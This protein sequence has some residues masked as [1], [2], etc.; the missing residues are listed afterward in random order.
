[1]VKRRKI[2]RKLLVLLL[3]LGL[4]SAV[5]AATVN[6]TINGGTEYVGTP[7]EVVTIKVIADAKCFGISSLMAAEATTVNSA[8]RGTA[9]TDWDCPAL[10]TPGAGMTIAEPGYL[11]NSG[12]N[13]VLFDFFSEYSAD[14]VAAGT[15]LASF[16]YT[17][18][19]VLGYW[20]APLET[21]TLY[22]DI[23]GDPYYADKST[24]SLLVEG[25]PTD[26]TIG[27]VHIIP[28]PVTIV[29]LGLGGLLLRRRK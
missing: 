2:M 16:S 7:G 27:G 13:G 26:V 15:V 12:T 18:G 28:E 21:G 8:N 19:S 11:E 20:V 4:A 10:P 17:I 3:V 29:L 14:G 22:Y 6:F 25:S 24:A 23:V 1:V 9:A 5:Q